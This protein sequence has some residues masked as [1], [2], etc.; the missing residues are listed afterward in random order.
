MDVNMKGNSQEI[1]FSVISQNVFILHMKQVWCDTSTHAY[2]DQI[3][4][5]FLKNSR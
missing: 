5:P 4:P 2:T 3:H 1:R